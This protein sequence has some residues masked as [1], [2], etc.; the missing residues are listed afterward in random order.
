MVFRDVTL[1]S[2][3]DRYTSQAI[4]IGRFKNLTSHSVK[5]SCGDSSIHPHKIYSSQV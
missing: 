4:D 2:L 3:I 5:L 1:H